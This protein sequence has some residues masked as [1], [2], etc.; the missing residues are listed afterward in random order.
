MIAA[1][2]KYGG[3]DAKLKSYLD[4]GHGAARAGV[5]DQQFYDWL[6]QRGKDKSPAGAANY[7]KLPK[8]Y[9]LCSI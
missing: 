2:K 9:I 8:P 3:K 7:A 5:F 6:F 4:E 1:I